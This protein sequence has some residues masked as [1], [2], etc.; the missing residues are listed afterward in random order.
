[1]AVLS[2]K[3]LSVGFGERT[4]FVP[5]DF[6]ISEGEKIGLIG[7]NGAGKTTL[8]RTITGSI[9][10]DGGSVIRQKGLRIGYMQQIV[11]SHSDESAYDYT[12]DVFSN[13]IKQEAELDYLES[14]LS[15]GDE[16]IILKHSTLME[17]FERNGG[18]TY[19]SRTRSALI[20]LGLREDQF[21]LPLKRLSGGQLS[22]I[23][24]A[25]LLLSDA[26]LMLL[27]EPTNHLD[28]ASVEWLEGF[29][30]SSKCAALIISHDRYF[31]D[32]VTT[33][34]LEIEHERIAD[35]KGSYSRYLELKKEQR[36]IQRRH[37]E[38]TLAEI[39][40]L[41]AVIKQQHQW[42]REKN[43]KTADS[44]Q[45]QVD[46]LR[47]T[48]IKPESELEEIR[49][50]F[51]PRLTSGSEVVVA[52]G[53][54]R[55]FGEHR[56]Y[57]NVSFKIRRGERVFLLGE[58][59]CGKTTLLRQLMTEGD[60]VKFG[61]SVSTS[62][63][64]QTQ[65]DLH[66]ENTAL[67]EIWSVYPSMSQSEVRSALAAFLFKGDDVFKPVGSLSGGER[68][69][70]AILKMMLAGNNFLLLD[71]PTNHLDI[72]ARQAL[73]QALS[74]Y[75][76]TMLIVSHDR[77][78]IDK[79]A[80]RIFVIENGGITQYD[81]NY[82]YYLQKRSPEAA[83]RETARKTIGTGG[84]TYKAKKELASQIRKQRSAVSAIE[85][86]TASL[87][88]ELD[89]IGA[90]MSNPEV[91]ADYEQTLELTARAEEIN[92]RLSKLMEDWTAA[93]ELLEQL[94]SRQRELTADNG[95]GN[96]NQ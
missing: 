51:K 53:L 19:K 35:F 48:L 23:S 93:G 30:R 44:K 61:P 72:Y 28:I 88:N 96:E 15:S 78:F 25:R 75:S 74:D 58:N 92:T 22:K 43:I 45:K 46:K 55:G 21:S 39:E 11:A 73:E 50:R 94:E 65:S 42:N 32:A 54:S 14:M 91:A 90:K 87:E 68:A 95:G 24:L 69:R 56:L 81:G 71:E 49:F 27:D 8:F 47:E 17:Q 33:R 89:D 18:L 60:G 20:G 10:P 76:G 7:A 59:G 64:D 31:L 36:E 37:Y 77:R 66:D 34:T 84:M 52:D 70:L 12:L 63:F 5:S 62:Y 9:R 85:S 29:I 41:E 79:L 26:Q 83:P 82:T 16:E 6:E 57:S 13:L 86:E 80:D 2:V 4:L 38:N 40:R 67:E 1:M 3:S